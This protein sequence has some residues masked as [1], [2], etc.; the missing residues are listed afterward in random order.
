[1]CDGV[2]V[3]VVKENVDE[4]VCGGVRVYVCVFREGIHIRLVSS[5]SKDQVE[6]S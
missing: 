2:S 4:R 3:C 6:A 5:I 1:M